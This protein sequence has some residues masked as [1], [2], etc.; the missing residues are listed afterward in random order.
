MGEL[1][2]SLGSVDLP[3]V[4]I[5]SFSEEGPRDRWRT[6]G[7]RV[8]PAA[9]RPGVHPVIAR[10]SAYAAA[11]H[12][13]YEMT[14]GVTRGFDPRTQSRVERRV[15]GLAVEVLDRLCD[16]DAL[17]FAVGA[18]GLDGD[19]RALV[20]DA[21][22]R[23]YRWPAE[24]HLPWSWP[25]LPM[26]LAVGELT[27]ARCALRLRLRSRRRLRYPVRYFS[28]AHTVLGGLESRLALMSD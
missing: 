23:E 10:A 24:L 9:R 3:G 26:W 27:S 12:H 20:Y 13:R 2:R 21:F 18:L 6:V 17:P 22:E 28:A 16:E 7:G 8:T 11:V 4:E 5:L 15:D 25:D 19:R 14:V 1:S